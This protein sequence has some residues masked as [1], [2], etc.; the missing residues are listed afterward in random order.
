L[1]R[2]P[3]PS[4][5]LEVDGRSHRIYLDGS[6]T[7]AVVFEPAIGDVGLTWGLVLPE[8]ARVTTA[9]THDRP[10]LGDSDFS[11]SPRTVGVMVDELRVVLAAAEVDPPYVLV[12]H[13]FS[14]LTVQA[15]GHLYPDEVAGIVLV[16]GAHEDQMERFPPELSPRAMLAGL[17]DQLHQLAQA[18]RQ[19]EPLPELMPVPGSFPEPLAGAY[20][21]ATAPTPDRLETVAAEYDGLEESQAQVRELRRCSLADI[22]I[23]VLRHGISQPM[24]GASDVVNE[25]Y[26]AVWRQMQDELAARSKSG[27]VVVAEGAGHMIHHDRPDLVVE[28]IRGLLR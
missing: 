16:D 7:P 2:T 12:G 1:S 10:G 18:G 6:G 13:S 3:I 8:V 26:E 15:F 19:G 27:R 9:L 5:E 14:S 23:V 25:R 11:V 28:A 20:R 21:E 4:L 17:A 22:A 24:P